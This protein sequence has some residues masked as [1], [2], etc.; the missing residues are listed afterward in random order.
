[1]S[2]IRGSLNSFSD[3]NTI[4]KD[5]N[6][7][8]IGSS[9]SNPLS[10]RLN[11][12]TLRSLSCYTCSRYS[13]LNHYKTLGLS[14]DATAKEIKTRFYELSKIYHPDINPSQGSSAD[15]FKRFS[16]AYSVL[17]DPKSRSQYDKAIYTNDPV[18]SNTSSTCWSTTNSTR[19]SRANYAWSSRASKKNFNQRN[20][21]GRDFFKVKPKDE[22]EQDFS[23]NLNRFERLARRR[24]G[25]GPE[26]SRSEDRNG[27]TG[28]TRDNGNSDQI[29]FRS[30]LDPKPK[31]FRQAIGLG[32]GLS[33]LYF[34]GINIKAMT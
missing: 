24:Q 22:D 32:L 3:F 6:S 25:L 14:Q 16:E 27:E 13:K 8:S 9:L 4:A 2:Y 17:S 29:D 30:S 10:N 20:Q 15:G 5:L 28:R 1:M 34:V 19:R 23:R 33:L 11:L 18:D 12:Q 21:A 7:R 31:S 26:I